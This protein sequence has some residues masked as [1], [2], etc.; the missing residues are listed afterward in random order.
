MCSS[1]LVYQATHAPNVF[2][3]YVVVTTKVLPDADVVNDIRKFVGPETCIVLIQNGIDIEKPIQAAFPNNTL[4]SGLAF[5]CVSQNQPGKITHLDYGRL[6]LGVCPEGQ[7]EHV[8]EWVETL[9][10]A[11]IPCRA[12]ARIYEE[13]WKKL[14]IGRAH[15]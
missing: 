11:G 6:V 5:I 2:D 15:V 14:E 9:V 13:R 12:V 1:D 8:D 10:L 7:S 4:I 3:D